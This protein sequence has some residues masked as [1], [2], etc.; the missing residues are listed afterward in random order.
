M[1]NLALARVV[2]MRPVILIS[3]FLGAGKTTLLR[4]T[5]QVLKDHKVEADVILNDYANAE[6]DSETLREHAKSVEALAA[7]CACCEGMDF[8]FDLIGKAS[9]SKHDALII[10]LNGTADPQPILEAF[11]LLENKFKLHPRWH[12]CVIDARH[13]EERGY[14]N[15]LETIQCEMASHYVISHQDSVDEQRFQAVKQRLAEINPGASCMTIEELASAIETVATA[16]KK[17]LINEAE[18]EVTL[19]PADTVSPYH[20]LAHEFTACQIQLL[21]PITREK[22]EAWLASLPEN[23]MRAKA[24]VDM[25]H[26]QEKRYLFERI[27]TSIPKNPY[28]V[29]AIKKSVPCSAVLI[30]SALEPEALFES[31]KEMLGIECVLA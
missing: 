9:E 7:S 3:G 30:G 14:H 11:T 20:Q 2:E 24:L 28:P 26:D 5:L 25:P 22:I 8:L 15:K 10:E 12:V 1:H 21:E 4:N 23:I 13:F 31:A 19:R 29:R 17:F 18:A 16:R 27:G 6:I